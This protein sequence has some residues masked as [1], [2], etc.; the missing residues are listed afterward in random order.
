MNLRSGP[1]FESK[2]NEDKE[3]LAAINNI[4]IAKRGYVVK[5]PK[6]G[7]S[8]VAALSGGLDSVM[9]IAIL[10]KEYKLN[11][12]P[13]FI[14]RGQSAY[15]YE[16]KAVDYYDRMFKKLY[17]NSYNSV[18]EIAVETPAKEYK[19]D[20][21]E[22]K[23]AMKDKHLSSHISYPAR[24]SI[25]FLTGMEYGYSLKN[26]GKEIKSVFASHMS[27]DFSFHCSLTWT[28]ITNL[29]MC[30]ITND[31]S[32]QFISLPIE[33]EF[34]NY[35]DKDIFVKYAAQNKIPLEYTRSCTNNSE[36]QCGVCPSCWDRRRAFKEANLED[37]TK[38]QCSAMPES[39]PTYYTK[40]ITLLTGNP[41][42][43]EAL[44]RASEGQ[45]PK[46]D[47]VFDTKKIWLPEIQESDPAIVAKFAAEYG[48]AQL[49]LPVI[50][51]DTGMFV[52]GLKGFPGAFVHDVDEKLG[53]DR[54]LDLCR[55]IRN[56]TAHIKTALAYCEPGKKAIVFDDTID[57]EIV[58]K[59]RLTEGSFIDIVFIPHH[60]ENKDLKTIG[61][62]RK[63]RPDLLGVIWGDTENNFL[64]WLRKDLGE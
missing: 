11:V 20:L 52:E 32:W 55:N 12:F 49:G 57:G 1:K 4:L 17:P 50:K 44:Q 30:Q 33:M 53:V 37:H 64:K 7:E 38:Y 35:F 42:K 24:N 34:D 39:I 21:R 23:R 27:S 13:F 9:N 16:K 41:R 5:M 62:I 25:I 36:L 54:F 10:L 56:R 31:Y 26:K 43:K 2:E 15:I 14:N 8:V 6:A 58:E 29:T 19:D 60:K 48:A 40:V 59:A 18:K 22:V 46:L 47:V 45:M 51:M 28:R 63:E 61:E 3:V